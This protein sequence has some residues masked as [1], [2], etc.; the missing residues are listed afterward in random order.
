MFPLFF[1]YPSPVFT[2][3]HLVFL[4]SWPAWLL[5]V[6]IVL[7]AAGLAVLIDYRWRRIAPGL[8]GD[9]P[10]ISRRRTWAIW[11]VQS[12]LVTLLLVLLWQPAMSVAELSSQQNIIAVVVD[13]SK[14]MATPDAGGRTREAAALAALEGGVLSGLNKRFRTRLYRLDGELTKLESSNGLQPTAAATHIG[15]GLQQLANETSD[16]PVGAVVLLTDGSEN[17]AGV[18]SRSSISLD[19]MQALRNRRLPVHTVTFGSAEQPHDVEMDDVSVAPTVIAGARTAATV[20]FTQHGYANGK[21]SIT[22]RDGNQ[23]LAAHEITLHANGVI[24]SEPM[25]FSAGAAGAKQ[26]RFAVEPLAGESNLLNNALTRPVLV[27]DAKRRI[28]YIEGEPRWTFRFMRRAEED[29]PSVQIV[30]MLRTSENKIYRQGI[31]SPDE[32]ADG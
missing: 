31:N 14:S 6:F 26:L 21:A 29:D 10:R 8:R 27:S 12:A 5:P 11:A 18:G 24:Q 3:G 4:G 20:S 9:A 23:L 17:A 2:R 19:A 15:D 1:K 22:V 28:L 25:F 13:D 16:L 7:A 30:S 32:L